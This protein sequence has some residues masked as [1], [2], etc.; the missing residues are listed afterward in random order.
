MRERERERGM[1]HFPPQW[2]KLGK[3]LWS[4]CWQGV[5]GSGG[6]WNSG[7]RCC[8][9]RAPWSP[10]MQAAELEALQGVWCGSLHA[11]LPL[12]SSKM[13]GQA[14]GDWW[15][16]RGGEAG[17]GVGRK[18]LAV[19]SLSFLTSLW[20]Q[21][22]FLPPHGTLAPSS[23][24]LLCPQHSSQLAWHSGAFP[25]WVSGYGDPKRSGDRG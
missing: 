2:K 14:G 6:S 17:L 15:G 21:T 4:W 20:R 18:P 24:P 25:S 1:G 23:F 3:G 7:C 10:A 8:C 13:L 22:G 12:P 11:V 19:C 16:L 5:G 9:V